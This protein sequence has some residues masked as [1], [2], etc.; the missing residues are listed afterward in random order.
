MTNA[1]FLGSTH[2]VPQNEDEAR[3]TLEPI[4]TDAPPEMDSPPEWNEQEFDSSGSL[5]GLSPRDVGS[6]TRDSEQYTPWWIA[7]ADELHNP[8]VDEQVSSS[9]TAASR[10]SS[11][12]QGHGT[13][14]YAIGIEPVIR[15]GAAFGS[16]Y[17]ASHEA[18]IQDGAGSYMLPP[19]QDDY[20]QA[21]V[22]ASAEKASR[23]AFQATQYA[24]FLK[25]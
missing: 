2:S 5:V 6:D 23:E 10:E 17:F 18:V 24:A 1:W 20:M 12:Q 13:M 8:I 3:S 14:Q 21:L 22:S 11:G 25:G 16:D 15:P 4:R 9:G 19:G 7:G